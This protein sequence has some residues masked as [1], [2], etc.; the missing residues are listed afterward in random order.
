MS[1]DLS[2]LVTADM[3]MIVIIDWGGTMQV[4]QCYKC[5]VIKVEN[6][7]SN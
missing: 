7:S 5:T 2:H 4:K 3:Y 1:H 6:M